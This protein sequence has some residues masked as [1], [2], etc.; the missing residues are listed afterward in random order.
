MAIFIKN[1][2]SLAR[3]INYRNKLHYFIVIMLALVYLIT[4]VNYYDYKA[5]AEAEVHNNLSA[6]DNGKTG[7]NRLQVRSDYSEYIRVQVSRGGVS[8]SDL[9]LIARVIEGE[10]A[11]ETFEG[12]VAVGAVIMNR[13][14]SEDFPDNARGVVYQELAFEAVANGQYERPLTDESIEAASLAIRG[15]D[16]TEGALYYWNPS[17]SSSTWVWQ[18]QIFK[19]IG[20]HVFAR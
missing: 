19:K 7:S 9:N 16:P 3:K 18:R 13:I 12:K 1:F 10:A 4:W 6:V 17:K 11:D 20:R 14:K 2:L 15:W 5:F 8:N